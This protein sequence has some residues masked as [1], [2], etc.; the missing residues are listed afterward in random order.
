MLLLLV[1]RISQAGATQAPGRGPQELERQVKVL[2]GLVVATVQHVVIALAFIPQAQGQA[3][4]LRIP[5]RE[6][7][8]HVIHRPLQMVHLLLNIFFLRHV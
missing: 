3:D 5:L 2:G 1:R 8:L 4:D 6:G 7:H